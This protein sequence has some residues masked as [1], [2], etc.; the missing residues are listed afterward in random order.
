MN[1]GEKSTY[2]EHALVVSTFLG[3]VAFAGLILVLQSEKT[4][5]R[6]AMGFSAHSYFDLLIVGLGF[7]CICSVFGSWL[8]AAVAGH[9]PSVTPA[10]D[11]LAGM[12]FSLTILGTVTA[13]I[14]LLAPF[15]PAGSE[16]LL[17][18]S[19]ALIVLI[20]FLLFRK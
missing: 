15:S 4:F 11:R 14:F 12:L 7:T 1:N 2:N 13:V 10:I 6:P 5:I 18:F 20:V 19:G 17:V 16:A 3:A 8:I 9:D